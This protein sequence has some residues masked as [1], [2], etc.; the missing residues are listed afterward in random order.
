LKRR[1]DP[2]L[3]L[4]ALF[5]VAI[6]LF[7]MF[8]PA[9]RS[10]QLSRAMSSHVDAVYEAVSNPHQPPGTEIAS[11]AGLA[12]RS[13]PDGVVVT[14]SDPGTS[15]KAAGI[16][17][18]A[19]ITA[20]DG[21]PLAGKTFSEALELLSKSQVARVSLT[22]TSG[23]T[24]TNTSVDWNRGSAPIRASA[25]KLPLGTDEQGR[26]IVARLAQGARISLMV[27]VIVQLIALTLGVTVGVLGVYAPKWIAGPLMRLTDGMFAF[28]DILL[29]I[30]II[31]VWETGILPVIVALSITSWPS[32]SRLVKTQVATLK[33][34]EFVV[35]AK[36]S[37]AGTFYQ[38]TRHILPQ[39]WG[40][41]M[42]ISMIEIA[43]TILAESTLSFLGIGVQAPN[44]S[45]GSMINNARIDMNSH[46]ALLIW[47]CAILS[48]TIFALNF[49]GDG[50]RS[51]MDPKGR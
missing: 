51:I 23:G 50:V 19:L 5:L 42:A 15:G 39:L 22:A 9:I 13:D 35:A 24:E 14:N 48:L 28:P 33:D 1:R 10:R 36:A 27:G 12:L 8:G 30:L 21:T 38:V 34:R 32:V 43:G 3:L 31:G 45:W 29:A 20:V 41:L 6:V 11:V 7:A 46:P 40:I 47:P 37:G 16:N 17:A 4:G 18:G 49:V 44:P 2:L 25:S 26:D